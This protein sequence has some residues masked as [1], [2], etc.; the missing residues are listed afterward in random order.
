MAVGADGPFDA[1][2]QDT[3]TNPK[4]ELGLVLHYGSANDGDISKSW[5]E[6]RAQPLPPRRSAGPI[7]WSHKDPISDFVFAQD[8][9]SAGAFRPYYRDQDRRYAKTDGVDMRWEGV[10]ALGPKRGTPRG[11]TPV[12]G[13]IQ[14]NF[15]LANGDFEEG[16]TSGWAAGT[17]ATLAV[18]TSVV[19]TGNYSLQITVA[20]S[21][22]AG[23]IASQSAAWTTAYR[24]RTVTVFA[25]VRRASGSDAG[26]FLRVFDGVD[27]TNSSAITADSWSYI[28]A[29]HTFNA[30]A[31]EF[32]VSIRHNATTS[33]DAH[34]FRIDDITPFPEGG[35]EAGGKGFAIRNSTNPDELYAA[36]GRCIISWNESNFRWDLEYFSGANGGT[37]DIE[38]FDDTIYVAYGDGISGQQYVYGDLTSGWTAS[39]INTTSNHQDNHA[40]H[41]VKAR[42]AYGSWAL[43]KSGPS[44]AGGTEVNAIAWSTSP[45]NTSGSWNPST[46]FVVGS[47]SRAITALHS[48]GDNFVVTKVDGIW[49]WDSQLYD[50]VNLTQEWENS[51][52]S[53]NGRRGQFWHGALY[54]SS[55]RQGFHRL[56]GGGLVD[57]SNMLMAPRL[58]D[59]G[60]RITAMTACAREL[61]MGLDQ[62]TADATEGKTSRLV[63]FNIVNNEARI[64]TTNEPAIGRID[65]LT[66]HRDTRLWAF[67]RSYDSNLDDYFL[68]T[69][70][71]FEPEK[72]AAPYADDTPLI[73]STGFFDTSIWTGGMPETDKALIALTIWC[74]DLDQQHTIQIDFGRDGRAANSTRLGVFRSSAR[75]QTLFF[76]N[77]EDPLENA[78]C[79]FAQLRFTFNTDDTV[80]PKLYAFALHTQL[81]PEPIKVWDVNAT[82]GDKTLMRTGVPLVENKAG[83]QRIFSELEAQVFPL[84]LVE[85]FGQSH[86]GAEQDGANVHQVR[87]V[88]YARQPKTSDEFGEE[89]WTLR[90]QEVPVSDG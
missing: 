21:T 4:I 82:V 70:L 47:A 23:A 60:G 61:I 51:S 41:L 55:I 34:I 62:P 6:G 17:G 45:T 3:E 59:F 68:S 56:D 9:W 69:T 11:S 36:V 54:L 74:E 50:F 52:D 71:W 88:S 20:Q 75:V 86:G 35:V 18:N 67:G 57:I 37:T 5:V 76:K 65:A 73:E 24:S 22:A 33:T 49:T 10:A 1:I 42:N 81:A 14:S 38:E 64:H 8:D 58:T 19:R 79:R 72:V 48:F 78:Q 77:I 29:A 32:T 27:T 84:T 87:L 25:Y 16:L 44:T 83:M 31:T 43:W 12:N 15:L 39:A 53:E 7:N 89:I 26:V 2:L 13:R 30:S 90:L 40:T 46:Y 85:D 28:S 66:L 63:R 80:S